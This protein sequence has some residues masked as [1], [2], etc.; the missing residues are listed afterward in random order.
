[1]HSA[2]AGVSTVDSKS[3]DIISSSTFFVFTPI[4]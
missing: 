2:R 4:L 3:K 1:M